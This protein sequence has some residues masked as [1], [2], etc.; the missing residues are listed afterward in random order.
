MPKETVYNRVTGTTSTG[1]P[2]YTSGLSEFV[3][4]AVTVKSPI[5][6]APNE[7]PKPYTAFSSD[8][9]AQQVQDNVQKLQTLKNTG[10]TVGQD[11]LARYT[12]SSFA[13]APADAIQTENGTWQSGGVQYAL[14][15]STTQ[16]PELKIVNDQI[17]SMK[18]Q[19]D[20][21]SRAMID[22]IKAQF[23]S[24]RK[25]QTDVNTRSQASLD[26]SLLMSGSAR[27][28]PISSTGQTSAMMSYGLQQIADLNTK[29]QNA[30]LQAQQAMDAGDM[31]FMDA[32]ISLAMEARKEKQA[33]AQKLSESL[34]KANKEI[35][36][37][38]KLQKRD[39][40][41]AN[42]VS[43]GTTDP[44]D[45]LKQLTKSGITATSKDVADV[46]KDLTVEGKTDD[47]KTDVGSFNYLKSNGLLPSG[48]TSL[49]EG[50]QYMAYLNMQKLANSGKLNE[51]G[52][53][54]GAGTSGIITGK[55]AVNAAQEEV[56]R[57]RLTGR[58]MKSLFGGNPSDSERAYVVNQVATMRAQGKDEESIIDELTGFSS[59]TKTPYNS[60]FRDIVIGKTDPQS[61]SS[62]INKVSQLLSGGNYSGAMNTVEDVALTS[63]KKED[64][65]SYLGRTTAST[66]TKKIDKVKQLLRDYGLGTV[67]PIS[68]SLQKVAGK[69]KS[70]QATAL[71]G[72]VSDLTATFRNDI[73]GSAVTASEASF[74]EP[75]IASLTDKQSNFTEKLDSLQNRIL[76]QHNSTRETAG[77]PKVNVLQILDPKERLK[78]Y[79]SETQ[80]TDGDFW[81]GSSTS[82]T[83]V[84]YNPN[85]GYN[86]P[87]E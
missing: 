49:P 22:N 64:P 38:N 17:A 47:L 87:T 51:A 68:G 26:Q 3:P 59:G 42:L 11:G 73:A 66:Y 35:A 19:F 61:Q 25:Q 86:I 56:I 9:G 37:I 12:D 65:S 5:P 20:N 40:E 75:L 71:Q 27:Y 8:Q 79:E 52:K 30:V 45:I 76:T 6:T 21:T 44:G 83:S 28:A 34:V 55:G 41:I 53:Y 46:L 33:T 84:I 1:Q 72:A 48:I 43:L 57:F 69:L 54:V 78:L 14:G 18:T 16:D 24:L 80:K 29:E 58:L 82:N 60:A 31:K 50:Q 4:P 85:T 77:L 70:N 2:I 63:A 23:E 13:S 67:G 7:T 15:P 10:L 39:T 32:S 74:L 81:G 62:Y 36:D